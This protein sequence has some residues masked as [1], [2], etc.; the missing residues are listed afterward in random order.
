MQKQYQ[1]KSQGFTIVETLIVLAIVGVMMVVIFLAVP[2]LQRNSR[3]TTAKTEGNNIVA[4]VNEFISNSGG[5][6]PVAA[7]ASNVLASANV[8]NITTLNVAAQ[9]GAT[10]IT[11]TSATMVTSA[12][13]TAAVTS[14]GLKAPNAVTAAGAARQFAV[15]YPMEDRAG[16]ATGCIDS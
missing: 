13:C 4:A 3:N 14:G 8:K 5:K 16:D 9:T 15:I 7:D 11:S 1:R 2:A 6:L 10:A 12:K